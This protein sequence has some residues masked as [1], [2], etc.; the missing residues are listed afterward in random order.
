MDLEIRNKIYFSSILC[1][2]LL[3]INYQC[4][5]DYK[6]NINYKYNE[7]CSMQNKDENAFNPI[8]IWPKL[9][10]HYWGK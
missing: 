1:M 4:P 7:M 3:D 8:G 9:C 6:N 10:Y 2:Q 5:F